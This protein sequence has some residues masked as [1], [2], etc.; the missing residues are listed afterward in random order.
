MMQLI[1][2]QLINGIIVGSLYGIIALAVS[3]TSGITGVVNFALGAFMLVGAYLTWHLNETYSVAFPFAVILV[4]GAVALIGLVADV[5]LFR[6]TRNN[7][8]NGL[9][10][11]IGLVSVIVAL[12]HMTWTS[13]PQNMQPFVAGVFTVGGV[14]VPKMKLL[15]GGVLVSIIG[16][17]YLGLT[18]TWMGRAAYAYAQNPEAA[19]LMGVATG[20]LQVGVAA[21][22]AALCGLAGSMYATLYSLTP[23]IGALYMLK[24]VEGALLAG[25]GS[26]IGALFGGMLIGVAEGLGSVFLPLA[27]NDAYG[28]LMLVLVLLFRPAGLFGGR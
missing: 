3:L 24:G 12:V 9:I 7:L 23:D 14:I 22:G 15:M 8:I 17:T 4:M 26:V 10:V 21:F 16:L 18:R 27:F 6:H 13:T 25:I 19:A 5:L 1:A 11:S 20:R 2:G 28:L